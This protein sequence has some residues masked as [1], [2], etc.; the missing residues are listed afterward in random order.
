MS[1]VY[2]VGVGVAIV[3]AFIAVASFFVAV[4]QLQQAIADGKQQTQALDVSRT[5]LQAVVDTVQA[6]QRIMAD[7]LETSKQLFSL[8]KEQQ[9]VVAKS[10]ETSKGLLSLQQEQLQHEKEIASRRPKIQLVIGNK[11]FDT[12]EVETSLAIGQENKGVLLTGVQNTGQV[13]LKKAVYL[14]IASN[15]N[16]TLYFDGTSI[17]NTNPNRTQLS[18]A[19]ILDILP[20]STSSSV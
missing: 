13:P 10:L 20:I 7:N 19:N 11:I 14:A 16:V 9:V 3:A 18:G 15:N 1:Q 5:Q 17:N 4:S 8:Q 2:L 12:A 6:Q